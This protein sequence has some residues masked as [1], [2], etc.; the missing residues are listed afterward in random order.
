[1]LK[2]LIK[3]CFHAISP[4]T[5]VAFES[6][7]ARAHSHRVIAGWGC[8]PVND[9]LIGRFGDRVLSGP[10]EGMVLT[11]MARQE[12]LGPYLLGIYEGELR[13]VWERVFQRQY[14]QIIDVGAK[15]GYYAVGFARR[16]PESRVVAFDTD[17]WARQAL[18]EMIAANGVGNVEVLGFCDPAW[19][20]AN[21]QD[22]ALIV[23][24]C[25]GFEGD[26]FASRP[27]PKLAS[28]TLVIETHDVFRPGTVDRLRAALGP[29]HEIEEIPSG[30][31]GRLVPV[32]LGFL[33]ERERALA[34][35]EVRPAQRYLH[36]TP[37]AGR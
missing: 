27:I 18:A 17:P 7:R 9:T 28:A 20:A 13:P 35:T 3:Q 5:A 14:P 25:E 23:S 21:L 2:S 16:Y 10:F 34:T 6:A 12:Q 8:G 33:D 19:L 30:D 11:P 29:T 4:K 15:F 24:D 31:A 1:M 37:K 32:D 36:G 22:G 26:L